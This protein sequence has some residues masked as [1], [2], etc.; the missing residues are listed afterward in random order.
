MGNCWG[1]NQGSKYAIDNQDEKE[2][3]KLAQKGTKAKRR[4]GTEAKEITARP[5]KALAAKQQGDGN[6]GSQNPAPSPQK[7]DTNAAADGH[8]A[9]DSQKL[10]APAPAPKPKLNIKDFQFKQCKGEVK[11]KAP[12]TINGQAFMIDECA[13]CDLYVL[14][15]CAA[16]TIDDSKNCRIFI[17]PTDGSIFMRNCTNVKCC[18]IGRQIRLRDVTN[19]NV[20]LLCRTKPIIETSTNVEDLKGEAEMLPVTLQG[21]SPTTT[22]LKHPQF[23]L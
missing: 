15:R 18:F 5:K 2:L 9:A 7:P 16:V 4:R 8:V 22:N 6:A 23:K 11:V 20:A 14:D 13:D 21:H 1:S 10:S 17:G 12:G 3:E 19:S